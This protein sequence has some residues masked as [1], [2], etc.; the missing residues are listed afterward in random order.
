VLSPIIVILIFLAMFAVLIL[1]H[2]FGHFIAAKLSGVRVDE[3]GIGFPPRLIKIRKG[4]TLYSLNLVPLGGFVK[5]LG[6]EGD[7]A[8]PRSFASKSIPVRFWILFAGPL[9]N[10]LL[11]LL[12]F[13]ISFMVPHN[14]IVEQ[15]VVQEVAS[16]SPAAMAGI[17]P[18]DTILQVNGHDINNR[19]E[20]SYYIQLGLGSEEN[21]LLQTPDLSQEEVSLM[22]RWN[23]PEG[24][25]A[26]GVVV[27]GV[28]SQVVRVSYPPWQAIKLGVQ[29]CR[30]IFILLWNTIRGW[31]MGAAAP[32]VAG[33]V[34]IAQITGEVAQA[35]F[36]PLLAFTAF[37]SLN[38]A[39]INLLPLPALD[40]GR[41]V[42]LLVELIRRGKR[43]SA[44]IERRVNYVGF[45][46]LIALICVITYFDIARIMLGESL[47]K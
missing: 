7:P 41:I 18:G 23:P 44:R 38:L 25:G 24:Q 37:I 1:A 4:E 6:E 35:G 8:G 45:M 34:G 11:P 14:T 43:V 30:E 15:V 47:L 3:F 12:L 42:F 20:L 22:P 29:S 28:D 36:S 2:E 13:S 19:G 5:L 27:A 33:P 39:I 10:L 9:M 40:G 32:D 17:V 31:I 21:I 46:L 26:I 16:N